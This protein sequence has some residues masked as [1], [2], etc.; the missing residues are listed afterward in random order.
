[1]IKK[2]LLA[3]GAIV[4]WT[5]APVAAQKLWS[6]E[7]CIRYALENNLQVKRQELNVDYNRNN[8]TQSLFSIL[9]SLNGSFNHNF[10]SG[11][12]IDY[13]K[14]E[15]V[16][17]NYW[18]SS[19]GLSGN[20][21][22]FSGLQ[23]YNNIL[24]NRYQ[25]LKSG[26]DLDKT[27]ND[28]SLQLTNAYLQVLFA[29]ELL[30]VSKSRLEV[31]SLQAAR[32]QRMLEAGNVAQG[33][34]LQIKAQE[35]SERTSLINASNN[36]DMA[37]LEL[38]QLLDLDSAN[39][40]E[41]LVPAHIEVELRAPLPS[42]M[43]IYQAALETMPQIRSAEYGLKSVRKQL[44]MAWGKASPAITLNGYLSSR[45]SE[46]L[47]DP[48]HPGEE[49]SF[50]DQVSDYY[51]KQVSIGLSFPIFNRLQVKNS[52]SNARLSV[53]DSELQLAQAKKSLYKEVQQAHADALASMEKYNS[54]LEAV[55]YNEEAFKYTS[56]K[57]DVGLVNS[58]DYSIAQNN[59]LKAQSDMLQAKYEYIFKLKIIDLYMGREIVL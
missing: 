13:S 40:F 9:P 31:T 43:D 55:R 19:M 57:Y 44:A 59:L 58:V 41:I 25:Y 18:S 47:S 5:T 10:S 36:L 46:L 34:F 54:S 42:V 26:A 51:Y 17:Q 2:T 48:L 6:L 49:Y 45:Y 52:I 50:R 7:E 12:T 4:L 28:I 30:E 20:L 14:F 35:A 15:Y 38:T 24:M 29:R 27:E 1:M 22:L 11:K 56:Q 37:Y 8:Y 3:A 32:M 23:L 21:T 16:D 39:G 53:T 33:D